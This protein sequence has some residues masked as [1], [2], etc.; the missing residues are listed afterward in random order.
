MQDTTGK[1]ER[2][3]NGN[4][5]GQTEATYRKVWAWQNHW[6]IHCDAGVSK[7]CKQTPVPF[8]GDCTHTRAGCLTVTKE[9][10]EVT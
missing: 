2:G 10:E 5:G 8:Y 1:V 3:I 6:V 4:L 7:D 9:G